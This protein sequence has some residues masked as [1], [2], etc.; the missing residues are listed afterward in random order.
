[1]IARTL[2]A[3]GIVLALMSPAYA[4]HCPADMKAIDHA[5]SQK[6]LAKNLNKARRDDIAA[7]RAK[8]EELHKGGKHAKAVE[9]LAKA[10]RI[11]LS[12]Q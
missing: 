9:Q 2:L 3:A 6:G 1:M 11:I 8:G 12:A 10:M 7:L 5:L 4:F